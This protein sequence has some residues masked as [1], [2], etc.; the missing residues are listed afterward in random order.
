MHEGTEGGMRLSRRTASSLAAALVISGAVTAPAAGGS[1]PDESVFLF[2][3]IPDVTLTDSRGETTCLSEL[4]RERPLILTM[5]FASCAEVCPFYLR[6]LERAVSSVGGAGERF[7]V[8]VVSFDPRD[9]PEAMAEM[10]ER[11]G[12][13][14]AGGWRFAVAAAGEAELLARSIGF[15]IEP[16]ASGRRFD[17]PAMLAAVDRGSLVR[18]LVGATVVE[19]RLR[20]VVWELDRVPVPI[21]P[22]PSEKVVFRCFGYD[23]RTGGLAVDWGL[24]LLATPGAAMFLATAWIFRRSGVRPPAPSD[25][26]S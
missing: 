22:L 5:V 1:L 13:A 23:P 3:T 24:L 15:W 17:H 20:E 4:W 6:S 26:R 25:L 2:Q 11:H 16:D 18:L 14:G 7:D 12:L 10:A 21:Y 8:V 9:S 19:R